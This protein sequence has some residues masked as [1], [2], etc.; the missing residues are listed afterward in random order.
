MA[1]KEEFDVFISHASEDTRAVALPLADT[2]RREGVT[3]WI[4]QQELKL[5]DSLR[6][7]IGE[8]LR[9]SR[10][11]IVILSRAFLTKRWPADEL[12]SLLAMEEAGR[13]RLLPIRY[14]LTQEEL[15]QQQPLVGDRL[16][17][18]VSDDFDG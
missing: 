4:D 3:V 7:K 9:K 14:Q 12:R 2:L 8:G 15:T 13:K 17:F 10:Y 16:S 5:G 11:G 6:E 1:E 18:S